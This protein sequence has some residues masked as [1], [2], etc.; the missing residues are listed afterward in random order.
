MIRR[1][2]EER[3]LA[4]IADTPVVLLHGARQTGK[5]TLVQSLAAQFPGAEYIT[6]DDAGALSLATRDPQGFI[7]GLPDTVVI[8]EVQKAP[9]LFPSIKMEV[10]RERRPGRFLLTG[11]ANVLLLPRLSESLAGRMEVIPLHPF[12]QGELESRTERFVD[13]L[14][15][16]GALR[17]TTLP[18]EGRSIHERLIRGGFPEACQRADDSRRSA[19]FG[20]YISTI[21]QRDVRDLA[22]IEGLAA[23][24]NLL[25]LLAA[26]SA[27]LL[28]MADLAR[29]ANLPHSTLTRYLT[30][31]KT[32]FLVSELPAWSA[33]IGKRLVK[34]PKVHL[35]DTGLTCHL[36]GCDAK[37]LG[38]EPSV[39]GPVLESFVFAELVK[40]LTWASAPAALYFV[41]TS[42]GVE[43]DFVIEDRQ[44][45]LVG[46]EVKASATVSADDFRNLESFAEAVGERFQRGVV[47]YAGERV[48]PRD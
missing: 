24:P 44:G 38:A 40:Q 35:C 34:A 13:R 37:R 22:H 26:R 6:L 32:L 47:L 14:L 11:S 42:T 28:N 43:V 18:M 46:I 4:A 41:R 12:S 21:L 45:R 2:I 5:T 16:G 20:S 7:R 31:L 27:G 10:D 23:L 25:T 48:W 1:N 15:T 29:S 3:V 9:D 30:I 19:W 17:A 33:N 39:L 36:L 8:D